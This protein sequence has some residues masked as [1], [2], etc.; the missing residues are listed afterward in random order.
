MARHPANAKPEEVLL[1][2]IMR[3][4]TTTADDRLVR[5]LPTFARLAALRQHTRR[6]AGMAT[7]LAAAFAAAHRMIDRILRGSAIVRLAALPAIAARFAE[8]DIHV[9]RI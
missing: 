7:A 6:T 4:R 5:R 2:Q 1:L 3:T 9:I 8:A